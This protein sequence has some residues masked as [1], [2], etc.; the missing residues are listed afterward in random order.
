MTVKSDGFVE[1]LW[2]RI[3]IF[4]NRLRKQKFPQISN[5]NMAS[6]NV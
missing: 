6:W 5:N 1:K 2:F 4:A 3:V